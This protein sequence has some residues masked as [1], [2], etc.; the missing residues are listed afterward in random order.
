MSGD[1]HVRFRERLGVR[2][3]RATRLGLPHA[4]RD[5]LVAHLALLIPDTQ[6]VTVDFRS[7]AGLIVQPPDEVLV[8]SE[9][10]GDS[11]AILREAAARDVV[12]QFFAGRPSGRKHLT[13][14]AIP[15]RLA[16]RFGIN[17][18]A[19]VELRVCLDRHGYIRHDRPTGP[20][21]AD[22]ELRAEREIADERCRVVHDDKNQ[23]PPP[24]GAV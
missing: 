4:A 16:A 5:Q 21:L 24:E 15:L 11:R 2:F 1:V 12:Q 6:L 23:L 19:V 13:L 18:G 8:G 20:C 7:S 10:L 3:P 9:T 22:T 17:V 14:L